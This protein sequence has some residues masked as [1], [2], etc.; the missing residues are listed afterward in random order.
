MVGD[1]EKQP[2]CHIPNTAYSYSRQKF[3]KFQPCYFRIEFS[4]KAIFYMSGTVTS[5]TV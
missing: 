1:V 3:A 2:G 4:S 5:I